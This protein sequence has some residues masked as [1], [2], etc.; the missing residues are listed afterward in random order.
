M[1]EPIRF[2]LLGEPLHASQT[3]G[4]ALMLAGI[5]VVNRGSS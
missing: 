5:Y 1:T 3:A 4:A 2:P